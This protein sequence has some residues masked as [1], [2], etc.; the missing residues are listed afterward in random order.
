RRR[1]ASPGASLR[2][3][4][5]PGRLLGLVDERLDGGEALLPE[6]RVA[7][8]D[9]EAAYELVRPVRA[10]GAEEAEVGVG[11]AVLPVAVARVEGEHEQLA[12]GVGVDVA[13][14]VDEVR[15]VA[16]PHAVVIA[17]GD[18]LAVHPALRLHPVVGELL[19]RELA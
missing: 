2:S 16:P 18:G 11:E 3:R 8:V 5:P 17:E 14:R 1:V 10:A 15:D 9:A 6:G 7:E 4:A 12:E 19:A 13:R